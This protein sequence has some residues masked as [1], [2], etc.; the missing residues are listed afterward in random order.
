M[1]V[2]AYIVLGGYLL[3]LV[4]ITV[5]CLM[6]FHLLVH[7]NRHKRAARRMVDAAK[8]QLNGHLPFVT[9]QLP[10]FNEYFVVERLIDNIMAIDY[11]K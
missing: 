4:L 5:Y 3:C 9:I 11:P 2:W 8:P 7:Y 10:I 1:E 6:Q